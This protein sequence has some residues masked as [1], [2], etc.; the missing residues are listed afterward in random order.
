MY[1]L[2]AYDKLKNTLIMTVP[3]PSHAMGKLYYRICF[4][5]KKV[6]KLKCH[7]KIQWNT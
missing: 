7:Q 6:S 4:T 1:F 5:E 2:I 3:W